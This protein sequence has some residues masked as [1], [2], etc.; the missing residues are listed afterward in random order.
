MT[1]TL[2]QTRPSIE[3]AV[4][5]VTAGAKIGAGMYRKV[6]HLDGSDWVY[7]VMH[8]SVGSSNQDEY[9]TYLRLVEM[10]DRGE[11]SFSLPETVLLSS[12]VIAQ[13]YVRGEHPS[14]DCEL[15]YSDLYECHCAEIYGF[16]ECWIERTSI[17]IDNHNQNVIVTTDGDGGHDVYMIDLAF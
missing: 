15:T 12:G 9:N 5:A 2:V 7:K 14:P 10:R 11:L 16:S 8:S 13:Q 6:Y 1:T 4:A 3:E 17:L